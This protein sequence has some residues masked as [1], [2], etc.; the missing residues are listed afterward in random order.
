MAFFE[1][2]EQIST[3]N[4]QSKV[5]DAYFLLANDENQIIHCCS[6]FLHKYIGAY[7]VTYFEDTKVLIEEV[8]K[9]LL[10]QSQENL[11]KGVKVQMLSNF[12]ESGMN[13]ISM[14]HKKK[15]RNMIVVVNSYQIRNE[16]AFKEVIFV[17]DRYIIH[18]I[19]KNVLSPKNRMP[20]D[21]KDND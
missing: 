18:E 14:H 3:P 21:V 13:A 9:D 15:M 5:K 10:S 7:N 4:L 8:F 19:S 16:L 11:Q 17:D 12:M 20:Y 1:K 2:L 6:N